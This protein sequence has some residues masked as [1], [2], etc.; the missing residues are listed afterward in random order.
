MLSSLYITDVRLDK[1][2]PKNS[3]LAALPLIRTFS[4]LSFKKPVTF[5]I[6]DNGT[7]KSTLLEAIAINYGFNPEGGS[8]NFI[9]ST[10]DT[11]SE[12]YKY[13]RLSRGAYSPRD[14]FF[15]RAES[16]YNVATYIDEIDS[17]PSFDPKVIEGFGGA[18][19]HQQS[20]GESLLAIASNRFRGRGLYILDEP[21]AA[22]SPSRQLALL[23]IIH[24]LV[25]DRSQFIITTHSPILMAYPEADI[26]QINREGI[27]KTSYK[28]TEHYKV[29]KQFLDNPERMLHY[30]F[31]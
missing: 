1:K 18:S 6:G 4:E 7:G 27:I 11:H 14:G 5:I 31:K 23:A 30:L 19:L 16:L 3:Y 17:E 2:I 8:R 29:T 28:D 22:L 10:N 12:L 13:V 24:R 9:F 20:H 26:F 21:E 25:N 15:L